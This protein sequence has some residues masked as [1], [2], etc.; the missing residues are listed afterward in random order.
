MPSRL[1]RGPGRGDSK[2]TDGWLPEGV[3]EQCIREDL[4]MRTCGYY[5]YSFKGLPPPLAARPPRSPH[6]G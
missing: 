2:E 3:G 6:R 5:L 4:V 1:G